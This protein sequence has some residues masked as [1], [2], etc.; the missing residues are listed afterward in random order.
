MPQKKNPDVFELAR[1]KAG[2]LIGTLAGL[3]ATLKSLPSAYDKDLQEDKVPLFLS[4]DTLAG[5]LPVLANALHTLSI[6]A[7]R[8]R[9]GI[10]ASLMATDLADQLVLK[11][12]P[13]RA[14]HT[15]VGQAMQ[16][17]AEKG[18]SLDALTAEG[19]KTIDPVLF[20]ELGEDELRAV[21]DPLRSVSRRNVIGGTAPGAVAAQLEQAKALLASSSTARFST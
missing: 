9:A 21:F 2:S 7:D 6:H 16:L 20:A 18:K 19:Y 15:V 1:G 4:F 12:V 13:F 8:M 14:A 5:I 11:G 17:A 10:D 3:M